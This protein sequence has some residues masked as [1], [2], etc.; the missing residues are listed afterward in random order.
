VVL[1]TVHAITQGTPLFSDSLSQPDPTWANEPG[2]C[3]FQNGS[4]VVKYDRPNGSSFG[5]DATSTN[6][7]NVA[8]QMDITLNS[9]AKASILFRADEYFSQMYYFAITQNQYAEF[10]LFGPNAGAVTPL[11]DPTFN[12]AI[13]GTGKKNTLLL[14][15]RGNFFQLFVNGTLVGE[16]H[17]GTMT[18]GK[19][20]M[21]VTDENQSTQA[22]FSNVVV[23]PI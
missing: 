5:C 11:M 17:D 1:A 6:F 2:K 21:G 9:G 22:S 4:Y 7:G 15:A 12:N 19:I 18:A 14:L 16:A 23:Y 3:F 20:G 10:T 13:Q 8:V